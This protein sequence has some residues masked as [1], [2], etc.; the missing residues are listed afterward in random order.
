MTTTGDSGA[1]CSVEAHAEIAA[2]GLLASAIDC[3]ESRP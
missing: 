3:G 2:R 1:L